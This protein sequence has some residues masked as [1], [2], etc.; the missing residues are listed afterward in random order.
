MKFQTTVSAIG[1]AAAFSLV[2]AAKYSINSNLYESEFGSYV[3]PNPRPSK[4]CPPNDL[5]K[6]SAC[7]NEVLSKLDDCK[8]DDLACECCALQSIKQECYH[9]CPDNPS[10]NFLSVLYEDCAELSEINACALPFKKDYRGGDGGVEEVNSKYLVKSRNKGDS[11]SQ[12]PKDSYAIMSKLNSNQELHSKEIEPTQPKSK[13]VGEHKL[14]HAIKHNS[15]E[16][17]NNTTTTGNSQ[18]STLNGNRGVNSTS[19]FNLLYF[20]LKI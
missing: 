10:A 17:G 3:N 7:C 14:E 19:M 2:V 6:L 11:G 18:N 9:I 4:K 15:T 13:I 5:I 8:P 20:H 1:V 16:L 12:M